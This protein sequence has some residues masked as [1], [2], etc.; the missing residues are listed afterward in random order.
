VPLAPTILINSGLTAEFANGFAAALRLRHLGRR[1][2]NENRSLH[3]QGWTLLDL[4][5]RYRWRNVEAS[6]SLLNLTDTTWREAQFAT[7]TCLR[8]EEGDMNC[9]ITGNVPS[10]S[11]PITA[12]G[13][14]GIT[15]T[16]GNPFNLR[17]GVQIFF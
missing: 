11:P 7:N 2:A 14:P 13:N 4:L 16:P 5:L 8:D 3:A 17:G 9:P 10:A 6:L 1:P 12:A 15:F